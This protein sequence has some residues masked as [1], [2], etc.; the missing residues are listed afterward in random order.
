MKFTNPIYQYIYK[1]VIISYITGLK[2]KPE[3]KKTKSKKNNSINLSEP[4]Y[5]ERY[6]NYKKFIETHFNE[7]DKSV[8]EMFKLDIFKVASVGSYELQEKLKQ[9]AIKIKT[10]PGIKN[11][12]ETFKSGSFKLITQYVPSDKWPKGQWIETNLRTA[13]RSS[14]YAAQYN[15]LQSPDMLRDYPAY[16][17]KTQEDERVRDEHA[18]LNN[19]LFLANDPIWNE[20]WPPNGWN[21]R[22]YIEEIDTNELAQIEKVNGTT[23][24][25]NHQQRE[26]IINNSKIPDEFQRNSANGVSVLNSWF[27]SRLS[28][29][30]EATQSNIIASVKDFISNNRTLNSQTA[31]K[32]ITEI[33]NDPDMQNFLKINN[34]PPEAESIIKAY[35]SR[36]KSF[37][38]ID[39]EMLNS[40]LDGR[41]PQNSDIIKFK[42][43]LEYLLSQQKG[44]KGT[45]FRGVSKGTYNLL[46][47]DFFSEY[48]FLSSSI[49]KKTA[50]KY[51]EKYIFIITSKNGKLVEKISLNPEENEVIFLPNTLFRITKIEK[52]NSKTIIKM[53]EQ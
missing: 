36:E 7:V 26:R 49:N 45:T 14:Y 50:D 52:T 4:A 37:K 43:A 17:Y 39:F 19:A 23:E 16:R 32:Y 42:T 20:I 8:I 10:D 22:C 24:L 34:L 3:S 27:N 9:L 44:Y 48:K 31:L 51:G 30:T 38:K 13:M 33:L 1:A 25:T 12:T 40:S 6:Y 53:I 11:P 5:P 21:C 35:T 46:E 28:G 2:S 15:K 29:F 18:L 47:G 41:S